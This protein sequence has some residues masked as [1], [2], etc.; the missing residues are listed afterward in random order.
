ME[1]KIGVGQE[2]AGRSHKVAMERML[3]FSGGPIGSADWPARN[4]HTDGER[5]RD[6]GLPAPI[7]SGIQYEAY[8]I[9]LLLRIFGDVWFDR[10]TL[11]AKY[12]RPVFADDVVRAKVRVDAVTPGKGETAYDLDV[13]CE[14]QDGETV[15]AVKAACVLPA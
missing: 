14:N 8:V 7:A 3:A 5:A 15:L 2:F 1:S 6:A 12:T 13:R 10:G 4:L 11:S 9:D